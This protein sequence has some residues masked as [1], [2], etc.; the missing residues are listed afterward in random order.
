M[1][2]GGRSVA[3]PGLPRPSLLVC[4]VL[5]LTPAF[6]DLESRGQRG[7]HIALAA[8]GTALCGLGGSGGDTAAD[9][10]SP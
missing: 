5:A 4:G 3:G 1:H 10:V 6:C 7:P 8:I 2:F 9:G